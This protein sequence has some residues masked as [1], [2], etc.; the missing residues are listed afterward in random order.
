LESSE[1]AQQKKAVLGTMNR[2]HLI[3][4]GY[5]EADIVGLGDLSQLTAKQVY[6]L[7]Q[8]K[9]LEAMKATGEVL[10]KEEVKIEPLH[11]RTRKT[12]KRK[13]RKLRTTKK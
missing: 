2:Q 12:A 4:A 13:S 3:L 6:Q 10:T 9:K 8:S 5:T 7:L 11:K 1:Q